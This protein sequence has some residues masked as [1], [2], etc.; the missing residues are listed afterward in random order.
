MISSRALSVLLVALALAGAAATSTAAQVGGAPD[1]APAASPE[2]GLESTERR[3]RAALR[4]NPEEPSFHASLGE[5]LRRQGRLA[6]SVESHQAAVR[7]APDSSVYRSQLA[8][9]L[10][11]AGDWDRAE[12]Q[13]RQAIR[14]DSTRAELHAGLGEA[15]RRQ[16]LLLP[17]AEAFRRAAALEPANPE[18]RRLVAEMD[19]ETDPRPAPGVGV[20]RLVSRAFLVVSAVVLSLSGLALLLPVVGAAYLLV[21]LVSATALR[22]FRR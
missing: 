12:I 16:S 19:R 4:L 20:M 18:F 9:A 5:I 22:A 11:E 8:G 3:L 6:E 2:Q 13:Y 1:T 7:L 17:A 10:L 21:V 15:L 14:L